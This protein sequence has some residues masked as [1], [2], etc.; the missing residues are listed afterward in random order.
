MSDARTVS[1]ASLRAIGHDGF[2]KIRQP[3][4]LCVDGTM[5]PDPVPGSKLIGSLASI[6]TRD[7]VVTVDFPEPFELPTPSIF[8]APALHPWGSPAAD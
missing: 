8:D 4:Y 3:V 1:R 6:P 2:T 5:S 7:D